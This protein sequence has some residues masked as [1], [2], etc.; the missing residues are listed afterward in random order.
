M[1]VWW[2]VQQPPVVADFHERLEPVWLQLTHQQLDL[3][4]ALFRELQRNLF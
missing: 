1:L 4:W 2:P 3:L